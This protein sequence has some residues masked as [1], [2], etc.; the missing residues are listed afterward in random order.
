MK[1]PKTFVP[2]ENLEE[3][4][5]QLLEKKEQKKEESILTESERRYFKLLAEKPKKNYEVWNVTYGD[6]S[7]GSMYREVK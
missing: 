1:L 2:E 5:K 7:K 3:K 4:T 6:G